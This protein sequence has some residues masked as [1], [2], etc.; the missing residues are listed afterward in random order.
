M[1]N[2]FSKDMAF[3]CSLDIE[4]P[5]W[6]N[7]N[8]HLQLKVF[9]ALKKI[10]QMEKKDLSDMSHD[11]KNLSSGFPTRFNTNWAV[12]PQKRA[13]SWEFWMQEEAAL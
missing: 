2:M 5:P 11:T 12:Q 3:G 4:M 13:R 7:S 8:E 10:L 9:I 6:G 1:Y